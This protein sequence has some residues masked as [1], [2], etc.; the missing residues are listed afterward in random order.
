MATKNKT[1]LEELKM[2]SN[3]DYNEYKNRVDAM[4]REINDVAQ[5]YNTEINIINNQR[6][7]IR[8]ELEKLY[9]F[10]E[11]LGNMIDRKVTVFD[12][13]V[14][15]PATIP[16]IDINIQKVES[17]N[18]LEHGFWNDSIFSHI[19]KHN[20]NQKRIDEYGS[21]VERQK[22]DYNAKLK[23]LDSIKRELETAWKIAQI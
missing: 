1:R 23:E 13:E 8:H 20:K 7:E 16:T 17:P 5:R 19:D 14:E 6:I 9:N 12:F 15:A 22:N 3:S 10:L 21:E 11:P 4:Q 18:Y 2:E